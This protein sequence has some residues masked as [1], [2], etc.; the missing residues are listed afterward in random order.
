MAHSK[1]LRRLGTLALAAVVG[2]AA[3]GAGRYAG[4][5]DLA[6]SLAV[7]GSLLASPAAAI[8][9]ADRLFRQEALPAAQT[10]VEDAESPPVFTT[11]A[12]E[13]LLPGVHMAVHKTRHIDAPASIHLLFPGILFLQTLCCIDSFYFPVPDEDTLSL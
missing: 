11:P 4:V 10:E 2:T 3:M 13:E 6:G 8:G 12:P 7:A 9:A 5:P 1:T